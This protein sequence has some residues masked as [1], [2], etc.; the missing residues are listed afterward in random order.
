MRAT[1]EGGTSRLRQKDAPAA[2]GSRA[3]QQ[4]RGRVRADPVPGEDGTAHV[5]WRRVAH[6]PQQSPPAVTRGAR[7]AWARATLT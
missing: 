6:S 7:A 4:E 3:P 5:V 2:A 1:R